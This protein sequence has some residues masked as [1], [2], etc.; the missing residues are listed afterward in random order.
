MDFL[1][2]NWLRDRESQTD[3]VEGLA[4]LRR[5]CWVVCVIV[6]LMA[7]AN[8][9]VVAET[10]AKITKLS[11]DEIIGELA[12]VSVEA[13]Q[14]QT[15]SGETASIPLAEI[16]GIQWERLP[17]VG[18]VVDL[19]FEITFTDGSRLAPKSVSLA[20]GNVTF[21]VDGEKLQT[22][23]SRHVESIRF[24]RPETSD[25][26]TTAWVDAL[27]SK[28]VGDQLVVR[29]KNE[30]DPLGGFILSSL[31]GVFETF[32][33]SVLNFKFDDNSVPVKLER[34]EGMVFYHPSQA[35][36]K[37][38]ACEA[39]AIEQGVLY[40]S[41]LSMAGES[42]DFTLR[43]GAK[44]SLPTG[45]LTQLDFSVGRFTRLE[46]LEPATATLQPFIE[47][48]VQQEEVLNLFSFSKDVDLLG[49][50]LRLKVPVAGTQATTIK[51]FA[52]GLALRSGTKLAFAIP[53]GSK[54]F[55]T[56]AG[57][58][59]SYS[60]RN[61]IN[62]IV[63]LDGKKATELSLSL[64]DPHAQTL[65]LEIGAAKRLLIEVQYGASGDFGD[66][67]ILADPRFFK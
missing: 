26:L 32:D 37:A 19:R 36:L 42:L 50:P 6:I 39:R 46:G 56:W 4:S 3:S 67:L 33:G 55:V 47:S 31:E 15:A 23:S 14:V 40:A 30:D 51:E 2:V 24:F 38:L 11:G 59:V 20:D 64:K 25:R 35:D 44:I 18:E 63:Q 22:V 28:V 17:S 21:N 34:M 9:V 61:T 16:E 43:C 62:L 12:A 66:Q 8:N 7:W 1:L 52:H 13:I 48:L 29:K 53:P 57:L 45:Y 58:P 65:D 5:A 49:K 54:R 10:T 27:E 41:E 60:D